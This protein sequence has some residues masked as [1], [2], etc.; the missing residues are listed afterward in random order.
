M[1]E[2][3]NEIT[4]IFIDAIR[5]E[6]I[7]KFLQIF[8]TNYGIIIENGM[9]TL[10]NICQ[11]PNLFSGKLDVKL[12]YDN[13][14]AKEVLDSLM[15]TRRSVIIDSNKY[16]WNISIEQEED[17]FPAPELDPNI[18]NEELARRCWAPMKI[19]VPRNIHP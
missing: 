17:M 14:Y 16:A 13:I 10:H 1:G 8:K 18:T 2:N 11:S 6:D 19:K 3:N 7:D 12:W 5:E 15:E 9:N 4:H